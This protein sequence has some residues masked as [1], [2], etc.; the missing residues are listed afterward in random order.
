MKAIVQEHG[1]DVV[2]RVMEVYLESTAV[3]Y[4]S[5]NAFMNKF[6]LW[7]N[8]VIPPARKENPYKFVPH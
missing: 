3:E 7:K 1:V 8:K 5:L 6:K 4:I 2:K